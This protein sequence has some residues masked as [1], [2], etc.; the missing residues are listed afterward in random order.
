MKIDAKQDLK[1]GAR[2]LAKAMDNQFLMQIVGV[3]ESELEVLFPTVDFPVAGM[4]LSLEFHDEQGYTVYPTEVLAAMPAFDKPARLKYPQEVI[5]NFH[6]QNFRVSTDL[7][8]QIKEQIH[9][10]KYDAA[11]LNLSAGGALVRT[12]G[13]FVMDATVELFLSLPRQPMLQV[14]GRVIHVIQEVDTGLPILGIRFINPSEEV[15]QGVSHYVGRQIN[16][17]FG[18]AGAS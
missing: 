11:L 5:R 15:Q 12:E 7:T 8:A 1:A 9:L 10:R 18:V 3:S 17:H 16:D 14:L 13:P 2:C 6:R 4:T